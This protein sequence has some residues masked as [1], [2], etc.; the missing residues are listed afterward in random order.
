MTVKEVID[1][2][3][4]ELGTVENPPNSNC[5][6]YNDWFYNKQGVSGAAYPWCCT[7]ICWLFRKEPRL[8]KKTA[9][10]MDL[11][12]WFKMNGQIVKSPQAGDIVFFKYNTNNRFTN[13]V[14]LVISVDGKIINTIEG[15]TSANGSQDNGGKVMQR[16][17]Y[18]NIVGYGRPKYSDKVSSVGVS[19]D[20]PAELEKVARDVIAGKYGNGKAVRK[21]NLERA[22][23]NY[24]AIQAIVNRILKEGK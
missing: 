4:G 17:R 23:Y 9:S 22:G 3:K 19:D 5:V 8:I 20:K 2:A 6:K 21:A 12:N 24:D 14:G 15:N 1:I 7:F 18:S 13:H 16:N 11:Y 10:C